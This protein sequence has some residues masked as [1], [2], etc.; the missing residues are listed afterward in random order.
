MPLGGVQAIGART[1]TSSL[2]GN[3]RTDARSRAEFFALAGLSG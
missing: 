2:L 1:V 3:L